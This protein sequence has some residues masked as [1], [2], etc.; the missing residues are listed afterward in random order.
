M[1]GK[2][3][4]HSEPDAF[5]EIELDGRVF[6][7]AY[8]YEGLEAAVAELKR[9]KVV[10]NLITA[11]NPAEMDYDSLGPL[12]YGA[13]HSAAPEL[14]YKQVESLITFQNAGMVYNKIIDAYLGSLSSS[15][16][17]KEKNE[18]AEDVS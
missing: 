4:A 6:P 8:T 2:S 17:R 10:F 16:K 7:L 9:Q 15:E 12:L 1:A 13:V 5:V 3:K 14:S 11:F 18:D